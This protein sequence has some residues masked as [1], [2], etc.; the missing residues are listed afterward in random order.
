MGRGLG[1]RGRINRQAYGVGQ[2]EARRAMQLNFMRAIAAFIVGAV[3]LGAWGLNL[4]AAERQPPPTAAPSPTAPAD[5]DEAAPT[6]TAVPLNPTPTPTVTPVVIPTM[7]PAAPL[8]ATATLTGPVTSPAET[9]VPA[10]AT[11]D[12]DTAAVNSAVGVWLRAEPNTDAEQLEW[13]LDGTVLTLLPGL[14]TGDNFEWQ[15]V[16]T[17][18]G[19]EGWVAVDFIT[20]NQ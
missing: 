17:P 16:R 15:Q 8:T 4:A 1:A 10:T 9:A 19:N 3:M 2:Q 7:T 11:P 20:Y 5:A 6:N 12:E 13:V 14:E 18:E